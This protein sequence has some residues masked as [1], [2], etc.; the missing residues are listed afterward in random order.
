MPQPQSDAILAHVGRLRRLERLDAGTTRVTD[1][2]LA[3]LRGLSELR[4]CR[5]PGRRR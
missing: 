4:S 1:A 2:G 5:A 3:Q